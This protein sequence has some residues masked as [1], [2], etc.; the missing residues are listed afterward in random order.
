MQA[1]K[2]VEDALVQYGQERNRH[3]ALLKA[4]DQARH[5]RI[6]TEQIYSQGLADQTA[7]LEAER[8]VFQAEDELAQSAAS[9]RVGLVSVYKA[10]G[11]GWEV[12]G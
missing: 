10:L 5:A 11:G 7:T 3:E 6:V 12:K 8:A 9:L 4:V 2:D 1:L